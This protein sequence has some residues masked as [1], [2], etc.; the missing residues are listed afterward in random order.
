[1]SVVAKFR[2][3]SLTS[4]NYD[5]PQYD[6]QKRYTG[7]IKQEM[8]TIKLVP[9]YSEDPNSENKKFWDAS[10]SGEIN[11]GTVNPAAWGYFD[12][13]GEYLITFEKVNPPVA[14]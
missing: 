7:S 10:P 6:E 9:V 8:R 12:L 11:L 3:L 13:E 1:M 4:T 5:K 14:K 2:V